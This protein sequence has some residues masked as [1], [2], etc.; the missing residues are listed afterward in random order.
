MLHQK[1]I[2][3][4]NAL[5]LELKVFAKQKEETFITDFPYW[6]DG[7]RKWETW[8]PKFPQGGSGGHEQIWYKRTSECIAEQK[9]EAEWERE[10]WHAWIG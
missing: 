2:S 7:M 4:T 6:N 5:F 8:G 9:C 10:S 1:H 3:L